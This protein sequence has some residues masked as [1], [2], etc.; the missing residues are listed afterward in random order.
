[1]S[2]YVC[3]LRIH[4]SGMYVQSY[5]R[6]SK[7]LNIQPLILSDLLTSDYRIRASHALYRTEYG[8]AYTPRLSPGR[9]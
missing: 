9:C 4:N 7:N 5:D 1:M 8:L 6:I 3:T 2:D